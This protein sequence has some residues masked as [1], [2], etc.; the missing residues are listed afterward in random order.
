LVNSQKCNGITS[1]NTIKTQGGQ[2][3]RYED[4]TFGKLSVDVRYWSKAVGQLWTN[5]HEESKALK[6]A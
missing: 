5:L 6:I 3:T 2:L 4:R 1:E